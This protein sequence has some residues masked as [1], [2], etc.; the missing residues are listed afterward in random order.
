MIGAMALF[1]ALG[2]MVKHAAASLSS[3]AVVFYRNFFG[4]LALA[5]LA[6]RGGLRGLKTRHFGQ[7]LYRAVSGLAAM[8]CS[9]YA[10]A[11]LP[12]ADALVLGYTS[13][14]F[15]PLMARFTLGEAVPPG[16]WRA[17]LLGFAGVALILKPGP[18]LIQPAALAGLASG[19][20]SAAAQV[21]IRKLAQVE[22]TLRIVFYFGLVSTVIS[23]PAA[24]RTW[25]DPGPSLWLFLAAMGAVATGGQLLLTK[26]YRDAAPSEVG[27]FIY[28][29]VVFAGLLDWI[30]WGR[31]PDPLSILG[32]G[33]ICAAGIFVIRRTGEA[34]QPEGGLDV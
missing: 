16:V 22:P 32:A 30:F 1:A 4:L 13:P 14:L 25:A 3:E 6:W 29:A 15:I 10:I 27:V 33:L 19:I 26:A 23:G 20:L 2:A 34:A 7:H 8:Y 12:L 5:P 18:G 31:L 9:F 21:G 24:L 28:V 11:H 17:L